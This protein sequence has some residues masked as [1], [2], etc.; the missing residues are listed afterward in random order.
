MRLIGV[1]LV[2]IGLD[3][4]DISLSVKNDVMNSMLNS[5]SGCGFRLWNM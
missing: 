4:S 5:V 2:V 1:V 3:S